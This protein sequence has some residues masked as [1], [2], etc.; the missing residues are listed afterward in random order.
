M[1][2]YTLE[3]E[4]ALRWI[5]ALEKLDIDYTITRGRMTLEALKQHDDRY[6][7]RAGSKSE[8][9]VVWRFEFAREPA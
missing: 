5:D 2:R 6:A 8:K 7:G 4:E 3:Q 9:W 1:I